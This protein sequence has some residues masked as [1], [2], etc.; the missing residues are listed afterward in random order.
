MARPSVYYGVPDQE[1][2]SAATANEAI[3]EALIEWENSDVATP[4]TMTLV[5]MVPEVIPETNW[6]VLDHFLDN[7]DG[8]YGDPSEAAEVTQVMKD[9][10]ADFIAAVIEEF[11]CWRLCEVLRG[12]VWLGDGIDGKWLFLQVCPCCERVEIH[13]SVSLCTRCKEHGSGLAECPAKE[14]EGP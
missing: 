7:L 12:E 9:A 8:E 5:M 6:G 2:Y 10:E 3:A 14:G 13:Q 4:E 1:V 11:P